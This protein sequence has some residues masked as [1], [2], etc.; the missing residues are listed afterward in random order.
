MKGVPVDKMA[1]HKGLTQTNPLP[2][3]EPLKIAFIGGR[4]IANSYSGIE[5]YYEEIGSRLADKGHKVL[6]YCREYFTPDIEEYR[7][8]QV[9]R[10]PSMRSKHLDTFAHSFLST[11]DA[12]R[13]KFDIVHYHAIGPSLFSFIPR[14]FGQ[15]TVVTVHALDWEREKWGTFATLFLKSCE[16]TSAVFPTATTVVSQKLERHYARKYRK[17]PA[18]IPNGVNAPEIRTAARIKEHR[19]E[20][21]NFLLFVGRLSPEKGC[22]Y[23]I[24]ALNSCNTDMKLVFAGGSSYSEDYMRKLRTMAGNN[25]V[26]LGYVDREM[27]A[28]LFTNCYAFVLPSEMEGLSISLLE[29]MSYGNCIIVS[30]IE[31]NLDVV[32]D[33]ALSF[34]SKD[35]N[36]LRDAL[37]NILED[38]ALVE[39]YRKKALESSRSRFNWDEVTQQ[40]EDFYYRVLREKRSSYKQK[41]TKTVRSG[42]EVS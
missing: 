4:G 24:E 26:F 39:R 8:L 42:E 14:M 11:C 7:G 29:A 6:V 38:P 32:G 15:K 36:S 21:D 2:S 35:V 22:H 1:P 16:V 13:Q 28:E 19:L 33:T 40:T 37:R 3:K 31:E 10:L 41:E 12:L 27:I 25:A 9:K 17:K 5:T 30:D 18:F 20:K 23:L 34:R